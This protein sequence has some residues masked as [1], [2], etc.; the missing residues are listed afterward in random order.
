M[1]ATPVMQAKSV[2][3]R[4]ND[5]QLLRDITLTWASGAVFSLLGPN[6]AGKTTLLRL[7]AGQKSLHKPLLRTESNTSRG[8]ICV[9]GKP[10]TGFSPPALARHIALV[11]QTNQSDFALTCRQVV[12]MG[13]LPH[14]SL[15]AR[16]TARHQQL[17]EEAIADVGL[18]AKQ[19]QA[20]GTMSGGEQQRCLI[21]RALVQGASVLILD[22]PINHLDVYYQHQILHLLR[23]LC[24]RQGKTV[25]MSLH[26]VNLAAQYSDSV[27]LMQQGSI[28]ASGTPVQVFTAA[29]LGRV[30]QLPCRVFP[31]PSDEQQ[32]LQQS[33]NNHPMSAGEARIRVEFR[34]DF[35]SCE[36]ASPNDHSRQSTAAPSPPVDCPNKR[37]LEV[38]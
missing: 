17:I 30:F 2:H 1:P 22:E 6:G 12:A 7:L 31:Q 36:Q 10:I 5:V 38:Q 9:L 3:L 21:A 14:M 20:Y 16:T 32:H 28:V 25:I 33:A 35:G 29:R 23:Q 19:Q 8:E 4:I 27:A 26:D 15:L 11:S 34:P 37:W 24:R 13:L 18:S